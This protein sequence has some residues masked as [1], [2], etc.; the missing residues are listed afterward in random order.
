MRANL[1]QKRRFKFLN[2]FKW[3]GFILLNGHS[4]KAWD[5]LL[6][7]GGSWED[8]DY[9]LNSHFINKTQTDLILFIFTI[10]LN[11]SIYDL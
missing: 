4:I 2:Y 7:L 8:W 5:Y 11:C 10:L 9:S 3:V 6:L 1:Y